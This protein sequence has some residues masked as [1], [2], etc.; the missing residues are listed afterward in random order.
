MDKAGLS[1]VLPSQAMGA[2]TTSAR[3]SLLT[4][5]V[6]FLFASQAQA[7]PV[8]LACLSD[9]ALASSIECRL[10][11]DGTLADSV[12]VLATTG[13][14]A[15][16]FGSLANLPPAFEI[17]TGEPGQ[18]LFSLTNHKSEIGV[19]VS[20]RNEVLRADVREETAIA[21]GASQA[22]SERY[23]AARSAAL[24]LIS[25]GIAGVGAASWRRRGLRRL[26]RLQAPWPSRKEV[27]S[28]APVAS[29]FVQRSSHSTPLRI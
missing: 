21:N 27:S 15:T 13:T 24:L 23:Q 19:I 2:Q 3:R 20:M 18:I 22:L 7:L 29:L 6:C 14:G 4:A 17:N 8:R 1:I 26:S 28:R 9:G 16:F 11:S 25:S 10:V 5:L 12:D